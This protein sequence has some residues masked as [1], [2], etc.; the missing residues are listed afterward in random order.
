[1][2]KNKD[3][4]LLKDLMKL[5]EQDTKD[6]M[7]KKLKTIYANVI[8]TPNYL[9]AEG[10]LTVVL[11][12]HLDTVMEDKKRYKF[13]YDERLDIASSLCGLGF[14]DKAGLAAIIKILET[15][16][17]PT[18]ICCTGEEKGSVGAS[19]LVEEHPIFPFQVMPKYMIQLD[20]RGANDCVFYDCGNQDFIK[21]IESFGYYKKAWGTF[22]DITTIAPAWGVAA[23]NLSIGYY[24]EHTRDEYLQVNEWYRSIQETIRILEDAERV[25]K[26]EYIEDV[27]D[28]SWLS[29]FGKIDFCESCGKPSN[30]IYEVVMPDGDILGFCLNCIADNDL[31]YCPDCQSF[32]VPSKPGQTKCYWCERESLQNNK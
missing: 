1:M 23:V 9:M 32:F 22:T 7:E 4:I 11:L 5:N 12:A 14:D 10:N 13:L 17:R 24:N 19:I 2:L 3:L 25:H 31:Q 26:F 18:I 20:R 15:G 21:Y 30:D 6:Y 16:L 27:Y 28:Y 8:S 29:S